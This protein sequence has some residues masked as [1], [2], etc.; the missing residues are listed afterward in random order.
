MHGCVHMYSIVKSVIFSLPFHEG[1]WVDPAYVWDLGMQKYI[2][3]K[4]T[5]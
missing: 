5:S 1:I 2:V 3:F 4:N